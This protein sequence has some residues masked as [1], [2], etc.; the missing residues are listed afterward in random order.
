MTYLRGGSILYVDLTESKI[1]TWPTKKYS[2]LVGGRGIHAKILYDTVGPEV[3]PLDPGS[4]LAIGSG[5]LSGT[6]VPG[7]GRTEITSKSPMTGLLGM[8][9]MGGYFASQL[10]WAGYDSLVITGI[11]EKP[12]YLYI[13]ND[14]VEIR[15]ASGVWG[16]DTY[17][18][19]NIIRKEVGDPDTE[20]I[21]IGQAG[22]NL[23]RY[24]C[25]INR[26]GDAASKTGHGCVMGSKRLKAIAVRGTKGVR[27]A[28]PDEFLALAELSQREL[29]KSPAYEAYLRIGMPAMMDAD[30]SVGLM[31]AGNQQDSLWAD[32]DKAAGDPFVKAHNPRRAGC[33]ACPLRCMEHYRIPGAGNGIVSC[34]GYDL[35]TYQVKNANRDLWWE[36]V[37]QSQRYGLDM[38]SLT[39]MIGWAMELYERGII[40]E[41]DTDGIP[42]V[43]GGRDAMLKMTEKI[44]FRD[45]FGDLLAD[46]VFEATKRLGR[47]SEQYM[48]HIKGLHMYT[49]NQMNYRGEALAGAVGPRGD[50]IRAT[51]LPITGG[52]AQ[53]KHQYESG[54]DLDDALRPLLEV[55][56]KYG[57]GRE[58]IDFLSYEGKAPLV[59]G[60]EETI[61]IPDLLGLCKFHGDFDREAMTP[62]LD[63]RLYE[64]GTGEPMTEEMLKFTARRVRTLERAYDCREGLT[65]DADTLPKR[66]F[67]TP[68][69]GLF[70]DDVLDRTKFEQMKDEYYSLKRWDLATGAPTRETLESYGFSDVADDLERRGKLPVTMPREAVVG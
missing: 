67:D 46:N 4:V 5:P 13:H 31:V 66:F 65:R 9:S 45:G 44:A 36:N 30:L 16:R 42:M 59:S 12:S 3:A 15:D 55:A 18:A 21:S 39:G 25:V 17:D 63:A 54:D 35:P 62:S 28:K 68:M 7:S 57:A 20:V 11:A 60:F 40:D 6:L 23:V 70:P 1:E 47:G 14:R 48:M 38:M 52:A 61:V 29:R 49:M 58:A 26:L 50:R 27:L 22:E 8:A 32:G 34:A 24:A 56:E 53:A 69:A 43:W 10:K 41:R 64:A 37:V 33:F 2:D 51:T 19:P